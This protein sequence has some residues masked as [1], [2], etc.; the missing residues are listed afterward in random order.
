MQPFMISLSLDTPAFIDQRMTLDGILA[1]A[2]YRFHG[3]LAAAH[4]DLPL[5][6]TAGVWHGSTVLFEE[7]LQPVNITRV[8]VLRGAG[9]LGADAFAPTGPQGRYLNLST[10]NGRYKGRMDSHTA[11]LA[12][13]VHFLGCGDLSAVLALLADLPGL[14]AHA[15]RGW[16]RISALEGHALAVDASWS[17]DGAAMRPVPVD[18]WQQ[19]IGSPPLHLGY[20][21]ARPPYYETHRAEPCVL[22]QGRLLAQG[23]DLLDVLAA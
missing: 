11:Y 16:G 19:V 22:P 8:A 12:P 23:P 1:A 17:L 2:H 5:R 13:Q 15:R 7:P 10:A 9:D 14:G 4:A 18:L 21:V 6:E 20:E 3:D